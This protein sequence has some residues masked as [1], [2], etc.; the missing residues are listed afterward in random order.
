MA[1]DREQ[2]EKEC[3]EIIER[4][5]LAFF[6]HLEPYISPS[7]QTLYDWEFEKLE[8]LKK[9]ISKN[10]VSKKK[11]MLSHWE[12]EDAAPLL[13]IAAFKLMADDEEFNKL[14]TNKSDINANVVNL[15]P[16]T[17]PDAPAE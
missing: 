1:Y 13:Q 17:I 5:K 6:T 9:A 7:M 8:S 14:T 2:I 10:R 15:P 16:I 3:I 4:E 12:K 11:K